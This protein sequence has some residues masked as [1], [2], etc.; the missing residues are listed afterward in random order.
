MRLQSPPVPKT[1]AAE[2][3]RSHF[4]RWGSL[5]RHDH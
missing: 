4:E 3:L 1:R 2:G 5:P